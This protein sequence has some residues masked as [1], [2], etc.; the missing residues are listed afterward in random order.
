M[1]GGSKGEWA[2]R[3][4]CVCDG[5]ATDTRRMLEEIRA[6]VFETLVARQQM[7]EQEDLQAVGFDTGEAFE[8]AEHFL[9]AADLK[10]RHMVRG[11]HER[12][13]QLKKHAPTLGLL[14]TFATTPCAYA[15]EFTEGG[16]L[17]PAHLRHAQPAAV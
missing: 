9:V 6:H 12:L 2:G 16:N 10:L 1:R 3:R 5:D 17:L 11:L 13:A 8:E 7:A 4:A 14:H 15:E